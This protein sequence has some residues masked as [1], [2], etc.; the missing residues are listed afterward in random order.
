ME[1]STKWRQGEARTHGTQSRRM[2][3]VVETSCVRELT[4]HSGWSK[5]V[6]YQMIRSNRQFDSTL[7]ANPELEEKQ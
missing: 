4:P 1:D 3:S 2:F 6:I 7:V 5:D